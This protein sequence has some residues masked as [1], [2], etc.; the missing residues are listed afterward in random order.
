[1]TKGW[2]QQKLAV[3]SG[4]W[5]LFHYNPDLAKQGKNPMVLDS[6]APS[7]PL[8]KYTYNETR[9]T[10]LTQSNEAEAE[11]LLKLGQEDVNKRW[12]LY[13]QMAAQPVEEKK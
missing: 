3:A 2:E 8:Q 10:M 12:K 6:K 11:R 13:E 5:P 1:M 7:V 4:H 9:Y